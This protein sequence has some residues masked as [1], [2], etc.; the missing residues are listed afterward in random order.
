MKK[1]IIFNSTILDDKPTGLGIYCK[2]IINKMNSEL[3]EE[4][5]TTSALTTK[6]AEHEKK[7][8]LNSKNKFLKVIS[9]NFKVEKYL[10]NKKDIIYYSPTQ[11]GTKQ[12]GVKQIITIHDLMPLYYPKGRWHQ[13]LYYKYILPKVILNSEKIITVS[14]N[15]KKDIIKEYGVAEEKISVIYNGHEKYQINTSEE[16]SEK[17]ITSKYQCEKFFLMIG[18]HY[19]YKNLHTVIDA[20]AKINKLIK[21][22]LIIVGNHDCKYGEFLRKK[23][24]NNGLENKV[25]FTSYIS[26]EEKNILYRYSSA[27]IYPSLYEGFGLPILEAMSN[28][29]LVLTSNKS[30]LPEVASDIGIIFNPEDPC[31]ITEKMLYVCNLEE[32]IRMEIIQKGVKWVENF[33]WEK[34]AKEIEN[35]IN[36]VYYVR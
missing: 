31:S 16:D 18:I 22:K 7:I 9:R 32:D 33:S 21:E 5:L 3:F 19:E 4:I 2:N 6:I 23:V 12:K 25:I 35:V 14:K 10:K 1:K 20:Y 13:Y 17:L 11:H 15:T 8:K 24:I 27:L 36:M 34:T 30:S 29:T 28:E 26:E